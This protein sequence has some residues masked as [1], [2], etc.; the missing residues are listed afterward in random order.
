LSDRFNRT[1]RNG[2]WNLVWLILGPLVFYS[3]WC[4]NK[5]IYGDCFVFSYV[6]IYGR[7]LMAPLKQSL[8]FIQLLLGGLQRGYVV[9]VKV[10]YLFWFLE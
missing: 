5:L 2:S 10:G 9:S 3:G 4:I 8:I 7:H 1:G 6:N